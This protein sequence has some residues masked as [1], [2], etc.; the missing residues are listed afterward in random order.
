MKKILLVLLALLIS[1]PVWAGECSER[2]SWLPNT[3]GITTGYKI[4]YG[5]VDSI[6]T[7]SVDIGFPDL[8]EGRVHGEVLDLNCNTLI[9]FVCVAYSTTGEESTYSNQVSVNTLSNIPDPPTNLRFEEI[10]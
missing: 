1:I 10:K 3:D 6:Y 8:I 9:Y 4:Y 7:E 5:T 2:F